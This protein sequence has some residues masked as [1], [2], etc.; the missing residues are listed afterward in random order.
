M[1]LLPRILAISADNYS[2]PVLVEWLFILNTLS[3]LNAESAICNMIGQFLIEDS[4]PKWILVSPTTSKVFH[5]LL[6][7]STQQSNP[8][9][10]IGAMC[11]N[12]LA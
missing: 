7:L 2:F 8:N 10:K 4:I 3:I 1:T 6:G 9:D 5:L 12:N 11:S